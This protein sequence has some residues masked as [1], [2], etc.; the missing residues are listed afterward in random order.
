MVLGGG[1]VVVEDC[2]KAVEKD[3]FNEDGFWIEAD[4][5]EINSFI[6]C[7]ELKLL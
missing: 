6:F 7:V 4:L 3:G 1:E 2:L 5:D